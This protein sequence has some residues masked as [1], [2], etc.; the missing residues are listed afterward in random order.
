MYLA[1]K[2][3]DLDNV[4]TVFAEGIQAGAEIE[5][6]DKKGESVVIRALDPI[7]YEVRRGDRRGQS[8]DIGGKPRPCAQSG[9]YE[10]QRRSVAKETQRTRRAGAV[11]TGMGFAAL[12]PGAFYN[13]CKD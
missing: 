4:A 13:I 12:A 2:V 3:S 9:Q 11:N 7:P 1:L 10:G 5:V 6:R 8:G